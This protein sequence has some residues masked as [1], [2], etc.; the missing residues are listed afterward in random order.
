MMINMENFSNRS[1]LFISD[2]HIESLNCEKEKIIIGR[3]VRE[4]V[5]FLIF[6]LSFVVTCTDIISEMFA[7]FIVLNNMKSCMIA[8]PGQSC[9]KAVQ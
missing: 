6:F 5:D 8:R 2:M 3:G 7:V 1:G 9:N 4:N